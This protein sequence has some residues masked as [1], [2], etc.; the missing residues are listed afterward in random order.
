MKGLIQ[1]LLK[2]LGKQ[3]FLMTQRHECVSFC[4]QNFFYYNTYFQNSHFHSTFSL[5][6]IPSSLSHFLSDFLNPH[7]QTNSRNKTSANW[8][9]QNNHDCVPKP[10]NQIGQ[11]PIYSIQTHHPRWASKSKKGI[12]DNVSSMQTWTDKLIDT[13][14]IQ[15]DLNVWP[16][17][18]NG[19]YKSSLQLGKSTQK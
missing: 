3:L 4:V 10:N 8:T 2:I 6:C 9:R 13:F 18:C 1:S 16:S 12:R 5:G 11:T 19:L 17:T 14:Y 15:S 7:L